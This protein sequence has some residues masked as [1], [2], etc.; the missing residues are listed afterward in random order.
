MMRFAQFAAMPWSRA[1]LDRL[2]EEEEQV[3]ML[4][5]RGKSVVQV[6]D[7]M[8]MSPESV[9]RRQRSAQRKLL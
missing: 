4:R 3:L 1:D 5:R 2:T 6:A 9:H 8:N 7:A